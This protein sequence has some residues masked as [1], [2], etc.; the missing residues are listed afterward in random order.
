M[1]C[2][3]LCGPFQEDNQSAFSDWYLKTALD[4]NFSI[5]RHTCTT[6]NTLENSCLCKSFILGP[7][8]Y[9]HFA[10]RTILK[11]DPRCHFLLVNPNQGPWNIFKK[12][13]NVP[14]IHYLSQS[15]PINLEF[16]LHEENGPLVYV[17]SQF[18]YQMVILSSQGVLIPL[19]WK[20]HTERL[21]KLIWRFDN[22]ELD[23]SLRYWPVLNETLKRL[24]CLGSVVCL[25]NRSQAQIC[26]FSFVGIAFQKIFSFSYRSFKIVVW[27]TLIQ[28]YRVRLQG[29]QLHCL[30]ANTKI[31]FCWAWKCFGIRGAWGIHKWLERQ[32]FMLSHWCRTRRHR[33]QNSR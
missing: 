24:V 27:G 4:G 23:V 3:Q 11:N 10:D 9:A 22:A 14:W 7:G 13:M 32:K 12:E 6:Q 1:Q 30:P 17:M 2:S 28:M 21:L 31:L 29:P 19:R 18:S 5:T 15:F 20:F 33:R 25:W 26:D 16:H 8:Y